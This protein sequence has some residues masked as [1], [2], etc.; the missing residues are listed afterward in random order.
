MNASILILLPGI[1]LGSCCSGGA[2]RTSTAAH[3]VCRRR[4]LVEGGNPD[5][6]VDTVFIL[7]CRECVVDLDRDGAEP[8]LVSWVSGPG[9]P[10]GVPELAAHAVYML[11]SMRA[12]SWASAPPD[13][14][15]MV[16]MA[17]RGSGKFSSC[18]SRRVRRSVSSRT[19]ASR[20]IS[21]SRDVEFSSSVILTISIRSLGTLFHGFPLLQ[22]GLDCPHVPSCWDIW[23]AC[24]GL[25]QAWWFLGLLVEAGDTCPVCLES[26]PAAGLL[27]AVSEVSYPRSDVVHVSFC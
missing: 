19:W 24:R 10:L 1:F 27:D 8:V 2:G 26:G 3:D 25:A 21:S 11:E 18:S 7:E 23:A 22:P 6:P 15:R 12:Q 16:M 14:A 5:Q 4:G 20:L 13:P 17:G 9:P